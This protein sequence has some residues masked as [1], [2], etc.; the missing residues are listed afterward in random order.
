MK[1]PKV[2]V[3]KVSDT[4]WSLTIDGV[5]V[6]NVTEIGYQREG[7]GLPF[8]TFTLVA[9][10]YQEDAPMEPVESYAPWLDRGHSEEAR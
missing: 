8:V 1:Y 7:E 5:Q 4:S 3:H 2:V 10:L 9:E 6:P